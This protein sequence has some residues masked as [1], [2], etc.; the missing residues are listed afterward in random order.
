[1]HLYQKTTAQKELVF[2]GIPRLIMKNELILGYLNVEFVPFLGVF[3][4]QKERLMHSKLIRLGLSLPPSSLSYMEHFTRDTLVSSFVTKTKKF[5]SPRFTT[6]STFHVLLNFKDPKPPK[7]CSTFC[8]TC[9]F[10]AVEIYWLQARKRDGK[11][12]DFS[13]LIGL[14]DMTRVKISTFSDGILYWKKLA[15]KSPYSKHF[16]WDKGN[17]FDRFKGLIEV[18]SVEIPSMTSWWNLKQSDHTK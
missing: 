16:Y 12:D 2:R 6:H 4:A 18:A 5:I 9:Q 13:S 7:V 3:S 17:N 11:N 14:I 8:Q 1:M 15:L 10:A